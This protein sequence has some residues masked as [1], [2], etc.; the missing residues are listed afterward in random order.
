MVP[1]KKAMANDG[2]SKGD[3]DEV[4]L[5]GGSTRIPKIQQHLKDYFGS[6]PH[7]YVNPDEAVAYGTTMQGTIKRGNNAG[8]V[9]LDMMPL[10]LGI[11]IAGGVMASMVPR[12]TQVPMKSTKMSPLS[13]TG[14]PQWRSWC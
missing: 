1:I 13:R 11:E 14:R 7:Q 8:M 10:T 9:V 6:E 2:L 12:N 3:V 5:I 4:M